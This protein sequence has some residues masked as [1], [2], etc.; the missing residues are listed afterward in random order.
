MLCD[1]SVTPGPGPICHPAGHSSTSP[2]ALKA[3]LPA[4]DLYG[5][6]PAGTTGRLRLHQAAH[7]TRAPGQ[8]SHM[9]TGIHTKHRTIVHR[10]CTGVSGWLTYEQMSSHYIKAEHDLYGPLRK[11]AEGCGF[12]VFR[13]FP[14]PKLMPGSGSPREIDYLFYRTQDSSSGPMILLM[15]TKLIKKNSCS[16]NLADDALKMLS[17]SIHNILGEAEERIKE[18]YDKITRHRDR[19]MHQEY[20]SDLDKWNEIACLP[21]DTPV[22]RCLFLVWRGD[23]ILTPIERQDSRIRRQLYG[24]LRRA[25]PMNNGRTASE[26]SLMDYRR[27]LIGTENPYR[28]ILNS[29]GSLRAAHTKTGARYW[30]CTLFETDKWKNLQGS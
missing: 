10:M 19:G 13:E 25:D 14:L 12:K 22:V 21:T 8:G 29:K 17:G 3:P 18:L 30:C 20:R 7:P 27:F 5:K 9:T 11:I 16:G 6:D 26:Y 23:D 2:R 28:P 24:L 15:E 4:V 1:F